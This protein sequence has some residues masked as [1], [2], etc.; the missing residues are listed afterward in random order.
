MNTFDH[1]V[2]NGNTAYKG[3]LFARFAYEPHG[4]YRGDSEAQ[5]V[6]EWDVDAVRKAYGGG[7]LPDAML[8][9]LQL[10]GEEAEREWSKITQGNGEHHG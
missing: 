3:T 9:S 2:I 7:T 8:H 1:F 10:Q 6:C 4:W 5:L